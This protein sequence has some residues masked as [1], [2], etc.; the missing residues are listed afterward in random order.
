[1]DKKITKNTTLAEVLEF[2]KA[3]EILV[4]YN[5]PCLTCP[6][7]KLEIDKLKLGQICQMYGIDLESLLKELNKNIK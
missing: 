7:A 4:K 3:Q 6:F 2:P 1:M 5:L